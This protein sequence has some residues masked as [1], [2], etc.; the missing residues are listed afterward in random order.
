MT[1]FFLNRI[2]ILVFAP[3]LANSANAAE[4]DSVTSCIKKLHN[5]AGIDVK[6][7]S[8]TLDSGWITDAVTWKQPDIE[9][10]V[11]G[12][13]VKYLRVGNKIYIIDGYSGTEAKAAHEKMAEQLDAVAFERAKAIVN[14]GE[15]LE[16]YVAQLQQPNPDVE[17]I[18]ESFKSDLDLASGEFHKSFYDSNSKWIA[19]LQ[20]V[21]AGG[22]SDADGASLEVQSMVLAQRNL[23][24]EQQIGNAIEENKS[25]SSRLEIRTNE[26]AQLQKQ[27]LALG[28]ELVATKKQLLIQSAPQHVTE[29]K[30]HL[31]AHRFSEA[32]EK[33]AWLQSE[34]L[35]D[36]AGF[37]EI[38][39]AAL[40]AIKPIPASKAGLNL[41]GYQ[42][43]A[44]LRPSNEGYKKKLEQYGGIAPGSYWVN[45]PDA[46]HPNLYS[47]PSAKCGI[48]GSL[49][50]GTKV[51][52]FE[53]RSDFARV[54]E[55][56]PVLCK[57]GKMVGDIDAGRTD[58]TSENGLKDGKI[59][60]WVQ[61]AYLSTSKPKAVAVNSEAERWVA[62]SDDFEAYRSQFSTAASKLIGDGKCSAN[63]FT[64]QGGWSSSPAKGK[65]VYFIWC[66][67]L[68]HR[69][70]LD[71]RTGRIY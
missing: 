17:K 39:S 48:V 44:N 26:V 31:A 22:N 49:Y 11:T 2:F 68:K 19:V 67:N 62:S 41:A 14:L 1:R 20:G 38:E 32:G 40:R 24:L 15:K 63:D 6:S 65:G 34:G 70:Y 13:G 59:A 25:L 28:E 5:H 37:Q 53:G 29:L 66:K 27:V 51:S 46:E 35:I 43:L 30:D 18:L 58:C 3:L 10:K 50:H 69:Y 8:A 60:R 21:E 7:N 61:T 33:L 9:C 45:D 47:C 16:A 52:V 57:D 12:S 23:E 54:T 36:E 4:E 64:S 55:Y 56:Y 42:F 71:V